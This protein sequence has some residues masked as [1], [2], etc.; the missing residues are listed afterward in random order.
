MA[1][2]EKIIQDW[3]RLE[4]QDHIPILGGNLWIEQWLHQRLTPIENEN[5]L[6]SV[7]NPQ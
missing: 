5:D 2:E 4:D 6:P 7:T 1:F 3:N